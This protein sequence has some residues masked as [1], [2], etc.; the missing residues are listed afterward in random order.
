MSTKDPKRT[1]SNLSHWMAR[2]HNFRLQ[3]LDHPAPRMKVENFSFIFICRKGKLTSQPM[4]KWPG[5][6]FN[7]P[8]WFP[9][10]RYPYDQPTVKF[11]TKVIH[12]NVSRHGDIGLD[13]LTW[14]YSM[15]QSLTKILLSVQSLLGEPFTQVMKQLWTFESTW[16]QE[17]TKNFF[18][19]SR[20]AWNRNWV[21]CMTTIGNDSMHWLDIGRRS[22][23]WW[24]K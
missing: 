8:D 10:Y 21:V 12:P 7:F 22:M 6:F 20:N 1:G 4:D 16:F 24:T 11:L 5:K 18:F 23:Q 13:V 9:I 2:C 15:L 3:L 17:L 14:N 19:L